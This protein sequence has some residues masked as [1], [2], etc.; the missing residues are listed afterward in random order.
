MM[1]LKDCK[2]SACTRPWHVLHPKG[3]IN[4]LEHALNEWLDTFYDEQ[5]KMWFSSCEL[6]YIPEAESQEQ[7]SP[8]TEGGRLRKQTFDFGDDW[9]MYT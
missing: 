7:V 5:P 6:G 2:D 1:V 8:F 4:S 9:V 3:D